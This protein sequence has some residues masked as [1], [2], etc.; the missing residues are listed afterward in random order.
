MGGG[1]NSKGVWAR[2][3]A[4][5]AQQ[6]SA[7]TLDDSIVRG[8]AIDLVADAS[9]NGSQAGPS[10][11]TVTTTYSDW[12]SSGGTIAAGT[13]TGGVVSGAG[14]LDV[15]PQ[16]ANAGGGD[17]HLTLGSP[18]VDKG[19]PGGGGSSKDFDGLARTQDGDV[20]GV[21]VS[22][23]GA[24]ELAAGLA[25]GTTITSGPTG[26]VAD[27]TPTFE[28]TGEAG[29]VGFEC[30]LDGDPFVTCTSPFTPTVGDG[31][32]TFEVRA[33]SAGAAVDP[34][35]ATR[36]FAVDT[37][38]PVPVVTSGPS[39]PTSDATPTFTFTSEVGA[40]FACQ[41]DSSPYAACTSPF[42]TSSLGDGPHTFAVRA[43]DAVA[44]P[45]LAPS[46]R[47]FTVDTAP[48]STTITKKPARRVTTRK[49]KIA[50]TSEAGVRF[51]CQVDG[52]AWKACTSPRRLKVKVG[53]H[54]LLVRAIDAAGN[55]GTAAR[56][57]F[58]RVLT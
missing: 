51:E 15:D 43:T 42:T 40:T 28:F 33:K 34:T 22:D 7:I 31:P 8:P 29:T 39:G 2:A 24:F 26:P 16:F 11:A 30:R 25:P 46:T 36:A 23:M 1:A 57:R 49:V 14:R 56:V 12:H 55:V 6:T 32:H 9:N 20:D 44:N 5:T 19:D 38:P 54:V 21:A 41:V 35:P 45:S 10:S 52:K 18:V 48:P 4:P 3:T 27:Q 53:K 17:Y 13:G 37:T 50:F 47:A 58:K